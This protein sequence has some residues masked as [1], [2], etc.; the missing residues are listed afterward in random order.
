M[1]HSP[2]TAPTLPPT[3]ATGEA[4]D[5]ERVQAVADVERFLALGGPAP[6]GS[7]PGN[8]SSVLPATLGTG[9]AG[10]EAFPSPPP[11]YEIL[12]ELGRG[13]MGVVYK[14][15]QAGLNRVVALKMVLAGAYAAELDVARFRTE[16]EVLAR[17]QHPNIIAI[18]E[19]GEHEGRPFFSLEYAE[20]SSLAQKLASGSLAP[21]EA[22]SPGDSPHL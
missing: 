11:G 15:R 19:I 5:S 1:N 13:G 17:L 22:A 16:A 9:A 20:G 14:A 2:D 6:G 7:T 4:P 8:P 21:Y 10:T 18:Y 12:G 3:P